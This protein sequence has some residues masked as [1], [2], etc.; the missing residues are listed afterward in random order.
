M[1]NPFRK[2]EKPKTYLNILNSGVYVDVDELRGKL[3]ELGYRLLP[4]GR[5][6]SSR[7]L[8]ALLKNE[9]NKLRKK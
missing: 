5:D 3:T 9:I 2:P 8:R 6:F 7:A 4:K 1:V